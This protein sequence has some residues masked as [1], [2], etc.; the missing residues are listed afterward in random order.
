MFTK[1]AEFAQPKG[2]AR[3]ARGV[4][5][6]TTM[7]LS[8]IGA[9]VGLS[10]TAGAH[11]INQNPGQ[12]GGPLLKSGDG[13]NPAPNWCNDFLGTGSSADKRDNTDL[14]GQRRRWRNLFAHRQQLD[15]HQW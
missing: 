11:T 7:L 10:G 1:S 2:A 3:K 12:G 15:L 6:A 4:A 9:T 8:G 5:L 13:I 14:G